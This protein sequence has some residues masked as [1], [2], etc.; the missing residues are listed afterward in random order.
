MIQAFTIERSVHNTPVVKDSS[1]TVTSLQPADVIGDVNRWWQANA[2]AGRPS[3]LLAYS[4]GKA[5]RVLAGVDAAQEHD[6][7]TLALR[8]WREFSA[9]ERAA[10][11][12]SADALR[13][14]LNG[15]RDLTRV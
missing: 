7:S 15:A 14:Q 13:W 4:L 5:Q 10:I 11:A 3:L 1:G 9:T 12:E 6:L 2:E 8:D